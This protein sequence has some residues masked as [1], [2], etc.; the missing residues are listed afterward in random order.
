VVSISCSPFLVVSF[1]IAVLDVTEQYIRP[2]ED[3]H[4]RGLVEAF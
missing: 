1:A 3:I 4:V 2:R